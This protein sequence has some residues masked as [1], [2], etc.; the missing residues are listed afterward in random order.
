MKSS[1]SSFIVHRSSL[2]TDMA[3]AHVQSATIVEG[4]NVSSIQASF[5]SPPAD[6]NFLV[7]A[8]SAWNGG[9]EAISSV[10]DNQSGNTYSLAV[11]QAR[12]GDG[13]LFLYHCPNVNHDSGTFTITVT[14][15]GSGYYGS[16]AIL[17]Y[18]GVAT[19]S[20]LDTTNS[21]SGTSTT[22]SSGSVSPTGTCLYLGAVYPAVTT[23][24]TAD[25][26]WTQRQELESGE[27]LSVIEQVTSG[28][29]TA[30]WTLGSSGGWAALIAAFDE[31]AGAAAPPGNRLALLG[32]GR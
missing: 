21:G 3:I 15:G 23:T 12:P 11:S 10:T 1:D 2:R 27:A 18:S 9:T 4:A 25:G 7:V 26:G 17:E 28:S 19:S 14:F 8:V 5:A 6:G 20:P 22:P 31:A 32:V 16:V 24:I 30:G 29:L 13:K